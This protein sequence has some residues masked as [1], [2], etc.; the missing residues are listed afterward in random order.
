[1]ESSVHNL[2]FY[3][4]ANSFHQEKKFSP[5]L[6]KLL[7]GMGQHNMWVVENLHLV[8]C[9]GDWFYNPY[10]EGKWVLLFKTGLKFH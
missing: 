3:C 5:S 8:I 4:T 10:N 7:Q 9:I 6:S 1:M 2:S